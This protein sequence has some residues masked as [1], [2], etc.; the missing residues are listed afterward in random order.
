M[1]LHTILDD[2]FPKVNDGLRHLTNFY[3]LRTYQHV[4]AGLDVGADDLLPVRQDPLEGGGQR[5]R[6]GQLVGREMRVPVPSI[7][8]NETRDACRYV[9]TSRSLEVCGDVFIP[10]GTKSGAAFF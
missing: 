8:H 7:I 1:V 10:P 2:R 9:H 4:L 6:V 3:S 5:L